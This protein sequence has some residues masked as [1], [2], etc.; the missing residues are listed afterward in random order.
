[1]Y[2][3][4]PQLRPLLYNSK[5]FHLTWAFNR[6]NHSTEHS[7]CL[8]MNLNWWIQSAASEHKQ[9]LHFNRDKSISIMNAMFR[10]KQNKTKPS[11]MK[12]FGFFFIFSLNSIKLCCTFFSCP[13]ASMPPVSF[14][15][16]ICKYLCTFAGACA[17]HFASI[18]LCQ[19]ASRSAQ[20]ENKIKS[21]W[22]IQQANKLIKCCC[23]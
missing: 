14:F 10:S 22:I 6:Y 12:R 16:I 5:R 20:F 1:M 18:P 11:K 15:S 21:S 13:T 23:C 7:I 19:S 4:A 3:D 2:F 17:F 9:N 8:N